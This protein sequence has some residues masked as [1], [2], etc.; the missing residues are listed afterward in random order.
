L[1]SPGAFSAPAGTGRAFRAHHSI[2][3][4]HDLAHEV[5][6]PL[7]RPGAIQSWS[8]GAED[9]VMTAWPP[10]L[11]E[12]QTQGIGTSWRPGVHQTS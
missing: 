8:Q 7:P 11:S 10:S 3:F 4:A 9:L 5:P 1:A 2:L 6:P 12:S